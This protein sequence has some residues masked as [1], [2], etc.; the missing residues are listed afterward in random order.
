MPS[1]SCLPLHAELTIE[2]LV[3]K[4]TRTSWPGCSDEEEETVCVKQRVYVIATLCTKLVY[5]PVLY[6]LHRSA[7]ILCSLSVAF[8]GVFL[9][10]KSPGAKHI[11]VLFSHACPTIL[12][13]SLY[14]LSLIF[15]SP[16]AV[17]QSPCIPTRSSLSCGCSTESAL[18]RRPG[19]ICTR[20]EATSKTARRTCILPC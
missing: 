18:T 16:Q 14:V 15:S 7:A 13:L 17:S 10:S 5:D 6:T 11:C 3:S 20:R 9:N 12:S 8:L 19:P 2:S 1:S 4:S